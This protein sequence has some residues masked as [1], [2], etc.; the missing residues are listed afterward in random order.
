MATS[1]GFD[2][3]PAQLVTERTETPLL[4]IMPWF[5]G[6]IILHVPFDIKYN[7]CLAL[8]PDV[9]AGL[10]L[11]LSSYK[12]KVVFEPADEATLK[13][14]R[15]MLWDVTRAAAVLPVVPIVA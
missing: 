2:V 15:T 12:N 9:A 4:K 11:L 6:N 7:V 13:P 10:G 5:S 1:E 8:L 3:P 14:R